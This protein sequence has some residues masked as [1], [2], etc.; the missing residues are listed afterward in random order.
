MNGNQHNTTSNNTNLSHVA[1]YRSENS[2]N[3]FQASA[4]QTIKTPQQAILLQNRNKFGENL[5]SSLN[6]S[7]LM[8]PKPQRLQKNGGVRRNIMRSRNVGQNWEPQ[9][10]RLLKMS[11]NHQQSN[12]WP[13][14]LPDVKSY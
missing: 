9:D 5:R 4:Q 2:Q 12:W 11:K 6:Q 8:T 10:V 3:Y 1:E 13:T 14:N 7:G